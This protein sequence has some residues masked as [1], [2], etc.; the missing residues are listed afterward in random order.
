MLNDSTQAGRDRLRDLKDFTR[1]A[2]EIIANERQRFDALNTET[3]KPVVVS[4]FNLFPTPPEI[5]AKMV[6]M[7]YI[8]E[9]HRVLEPSAGTGNLLKAIGNKP[10]KLAVEISADCVRVLMCGGAGSGCE[11]IHADFL[12]CTEVMLG[13]F[14]RVVMNPPF[15][16]G[17]D[18]KHIKHAATFLK[19]GGRL[20][21]LCAN[22]PRQRD[23]L[24]PIASTWQLLPEGS[25][26]GE[27][28]G[29]SVALMTI[30]R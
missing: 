8:D 14:D 16:Q 26:R 9:N 21:A 12:G 23:Q 22:G 10:D 25:F 29:V 6:D 17:R 5:A 20:V 11:I 3:A 30:D 15:K 2:G 27:G 28:T 18:I 1:G 19:P 13:K 4:S 24:K 7:A